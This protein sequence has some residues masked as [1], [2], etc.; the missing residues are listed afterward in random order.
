MATRRRSSRAPARPCIGN[1]RKPATDLTMPDT[2]FGRV[3]AQ[4]MARAARRRPRLRE[5]LV[6]RRKMRLATRPDVRQKPPPERRDRGVTGV[7][8]GRDATERHRVMRRQSRAATAAA[9]RAQV[10]PLDHLDDEPREVVFRQPFVHRGQ[11][12][13]RRVVIGVPQIARRRGVH[14]AGVASA[15]R[16]HQEFPRPLAS[17]PTGCQEAR[18]AKA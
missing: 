11:R 12:K 5:A 17:S 3:V 7:V 18:C 9:H 8:A 2:G 13:N 14:L 10:H 6:Q 1:R 16:F 4:R 15:R